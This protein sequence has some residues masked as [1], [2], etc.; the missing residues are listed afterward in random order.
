MPNK[1]LSEGECQPHEQHT[2]FSLLTDRVPSAIHQLQTNTNTTHNTYRDTSNTTTKAPLGVTTQFQPVFLLSL[3]SPFHDILR[4]TFR[5]PASLAK[6]NTR[7][8]LNSNHHHFWDHSEQMLAQQLLET[9]FFNHRTLQDSVPLR[10]HLSQQS[11]H[12]PQQIHHRQRREQ[13]TSSSHNPSTQKE[14]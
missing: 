11:R 5:D 14:L 2:T 9:Q 7:T 10:H 13:K 4:Q 3:P 8:Q 1:T 12:R 6:R